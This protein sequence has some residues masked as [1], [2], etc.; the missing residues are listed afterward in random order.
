[1]NTLEK[2]LRNMR[3]RC[4]NCDSLLPVYQASDPSSKTNYLI[5]EGHGYCGDYTMTSGQPKEYDHLSGFCGMDCL[6]AWS[7]TEI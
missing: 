4:A 6:K 1:M 2:A 7:R 5:L 3:I